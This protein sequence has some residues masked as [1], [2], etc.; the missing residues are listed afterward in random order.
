LSFNNQYIYS[1]IYTD[2]ENLRVT[3]QLDKIKKA[4]SLEFS[5]ILSLDLVDKTLRP[6]RMN[7]IIWSE[8]QEFDDTKKGKDLRQKFK[9]FSIFREKLKSLIEEVDYKKLAREA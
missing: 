5:D 1:V 8:N 7:P 4:L 2:E 3:A 9:Q 6:L